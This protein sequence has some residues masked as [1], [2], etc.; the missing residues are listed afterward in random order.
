[1]RYAAVLLGPVA[2]SI[3]FFP[4][5]WISSASITPSAE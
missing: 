1:M 5:A 2:M 4:R 3:A